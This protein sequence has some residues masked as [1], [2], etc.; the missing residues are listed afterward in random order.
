[1]PGHQHPESGVVDGIRAVAGP[2][3]YATLAGRTPVGA[4]YLRYQL[5]RRTDT[6]GDHVVLEVPVYADGL[7]GSNVAV[8]VGQLVRGTAQQGGRVVLQRREFQ[9]TVGGLHLPQRIQDRQ[10]EAPPR[11]GLPA[12]PQAGLHR[13]NVGR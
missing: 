8:Q 2:H 13:V 7:P 3:P 6:L 1:M 9:R 5:H 4:E 10:V 11:V 12:R